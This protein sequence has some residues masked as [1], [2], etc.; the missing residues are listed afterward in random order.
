MAVLEL[1]PGRLGRRLEEIRVGGTTVNRAVYAAGLE[2][3]SH[4]HPRGNLCVTLAG[5]FEEEWGRRR[6]HI[7]S[8]W[9]LFKPP[10][11]EH[12][13]RFG[14]S[15]VVCINLDFTTQAWEELVG[16]PSSTPRVLF[17]PR[18]Q[19]FA[20]ELELELAESDRASS[21]AAEGLVMA[22]LACAMRASDRNVG[23]GR[24][25]WIDEVRDRL[26]AQYSLHLRLD[27]LASE[28]GVHPAQLS[29]Q[30]RTHLGCSVGEYVKRLRVAAALRGLSDPE[31]PLPEVAIDAGFSDQSHMGRVLRRA[32]GRTPGDWRGRL[33]RGRRSDRSTGDG[34]F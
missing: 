2:T 34:P 31:R 17:E 14:P 25:P 8:G 32:T 20:Q 9:A 33:C 21:L 16:E 5:Q 24:A 28:V 1:N 12:L 19:H 10:G 13:D 6:E 27:D 7:R 22:L 26:H 18:L 11:I 4:V 23:A 30:F 29:R 15:D 3:P